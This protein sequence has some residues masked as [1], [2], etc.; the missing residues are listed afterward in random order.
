MDHATTGFL[1]GY[2]PFYDLLFCAKEEDGRTGVQGTVC[3]FFGLDGESWSQYFKSVN[4]PAISMA[5]IR[6][7]GIGRVVVAIGPH[8]DYWESL[9]ELE[10]ENVGRIS[11]DGRFLARRLRVI[12]DTI[13]A[14]GMAR[15]LFRR[16]LDGQWTSVGTDAI[17]PEGRAAGFNDIA[18]ESLSEIYAVGWHG[19]I[20]SWDGR[21]W[22]QIDSPTSAHLSAACCMPDGTILGVG[23]GGV[24]VRGRGD[25]W[26]T[27]DTGREE[28][29]LSVCSH[30][31][32]VF[33]CSAHKLMQLTDDGLVPV[34]ML[35]DPNDPP[36][37]CLHLLQSDDHE[38]L[39]SMG[40]KDLFRL[41]GSYWERLV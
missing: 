12:E 25:K 7:Q 14:A 13:F 2:A 38:A 11:Q 36:A 30:N 18:G 16:E 33:V 20:W 8:G 21:V 31:D 10:V 9:A 23:Y 15:K 22:V 41:Q 6:P 40:P 4:W 5:S 17:L 34:S 27:V 32:E 35:A 24:M 1:S 28:N 29:L 37:T 19:E 26:R 3:G 39:Y